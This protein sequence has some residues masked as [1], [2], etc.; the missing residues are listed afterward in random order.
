MRSSNPVASQSSGKPILRDR[1]AGY[2]MRPD[3]RVAMLDFTLP[4][5]LA[6]LLAA[7]VWPSPEGPSMNEQQFRPIIFTDRVRKFAAEETLVCL[8]RPPFPTIAKVRAA[9]GAGDFW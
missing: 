7:G 3:S 4:D 9:G 6:R 5:C 2:F 8:Q 1:I